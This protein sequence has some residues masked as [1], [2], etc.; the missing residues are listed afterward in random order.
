[1]YLMYERWEIS[2]ETILLL[3][4]YKQNLLV[5]LEELFFWV[6]II[7]IIQTVLLVF[8]KIIQLFLQLKSWY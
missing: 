7:F 8:F 5:H 1:M 3:S 2:N 6:E 4:F